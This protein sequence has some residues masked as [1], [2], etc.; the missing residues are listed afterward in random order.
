MVWL[1]ETFGEFFIWFTKY[2][3]V[4]H[5]SSCPWR[6]SLKLNHLVINRWVLFMHT[7]IP[8]LLSCWSSLD[9]VK[10]WMTTKDRWTLIDPHQFLLLVLNSIRYLGAYIFFFFFFPFLLV[11][12]RKRI[13][14]LE[15]IHLS[16]FLFTPL[17]S[18]VSYIF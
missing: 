7:V 4:I 17:S 9:V 18:I 1:C 11:K 15:M 2:N 8:R 6:N 10:S 3:S 16:K 5:A 14:H 13:H 12:N